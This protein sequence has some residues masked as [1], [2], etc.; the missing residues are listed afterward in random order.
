MGL[1]AVVGWSGLG[2]TVVG[3]GVSV[4]FTWFDGHRTRAL[5]KGLGRRDDGK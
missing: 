3:I 2:L 5:L 1:E 4:W